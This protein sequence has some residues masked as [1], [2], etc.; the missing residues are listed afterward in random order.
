MNVFA[1]LPG[2]ESGSAWLA[3]SSGE[4]AT[5]PVLRVPDEEPG[6]KVEA[7]RHGRRC[8]DAAA[9]SA[10]EAEATSAASCVGCTT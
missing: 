6:R 5:K 2:V 8:S 3:A 7:V 10:V 4:S 1:R 9:G